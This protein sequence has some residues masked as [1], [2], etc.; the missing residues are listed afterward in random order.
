[1]GGRREEKIGWLKRFVVKIEENKR[2]NRKEGGWMKGKRL[3]WLYKG[4]VKRSKG[5]KEGGKAKLR[6]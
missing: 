5:N 1:M 2:R 4:K 6:Y 3:A